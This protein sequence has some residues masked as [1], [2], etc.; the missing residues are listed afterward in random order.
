MFNLQNPHTVEF[1]AAMYE[2]NQAE[3][4]FVAAHRA[5]RNQPVS[6]TDTALEYA[7][8]SAGGYLD[9]ADRVTRTIPVWVRALP[10]WEA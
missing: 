6:S 2:A 3:A 7:L 1:M 9:A 10:V 5:W 4:D 8:W